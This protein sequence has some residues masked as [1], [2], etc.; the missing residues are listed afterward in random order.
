MAAIRAFLRSRKLQRLGKILILSMVLL[1]CFIGYYLGNLPQK[2][3]SINDKMEIVSY[4]LTIVDPRGNGTSSTKEAFRA[5]DVYIWRGLC[6]SDTSS[7]RS[8]LFFPRYP[9]ENF[10]SHIS[11]FQIEDRGISYG[12]LIFGF[13]HPPNTTLYRFAIVSDDT[14]ELWLS[15]YEDPKQK[16]LIARVFKKGEAAW[17]QLNQLLKYPDQISKDI[18]LHKGSKYYIEVLHKQGT[19][20]GFVQVFW[21]SLKDKDFKLINSEYLSPYSDEKDENVVARKNK[22]VLHSV[23]ADR[24]RVELELK[25]KRIS[26]DYLKFYSLPLVPKDSYLPSCDYESSFV[27]SRTVRHYEGIRHVAI[28]LVYPEDNTTMGLLGK[29]SPNRLAGRDI[30]HTVVNKIA[31]SLRLKTSK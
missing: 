29:K 11:K 18:K 7:L 4:N 24:Y 8:S 30:I 23:L 22:D 25:S 13:V 16:Q 5:L 9:D 26:K 31:T 10:R 19:G 14:S 21:K 27:L 1:A 3:M 17:A 28:S 12:Q 6:G 20:K 2:D 15:S